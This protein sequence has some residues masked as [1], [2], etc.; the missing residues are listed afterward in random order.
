[1]YSDKKDLEKKGYKWVYDRFISKLYDI[2]L[3]IGL[4]PPGERILRETVFYAISPFIV[5]GD[6]I[7]DLCCGTGTLTILLSKVLYKDCE[8]HGVDLSDGQ[9]N[10]AK[11]KFN[12]PNLK[13]EAMNANFLKFEKDHFDKVIISAALHEMEK[14]ERLKVLSEI[15]RILRKG[16]IF[17]I[18]DHHEPSKIGQRIFYNFY[19]GFFEKMLSN[20]FEMQR[21][22]L[23][24]LIETDFKI[25]SQEPIKKF[26]DF[27]QIILSKKIKLTS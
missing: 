15:H 21:N 19:L 6:R 23:M 9:I 3:K 13:F 11:K 18:L 5:H 24:E 8:I 25:I 16:G 12:A 4:T 26:H 22:I 7:L 14:E 27:F 2:G 20:S 17:L 10:Q 1:M